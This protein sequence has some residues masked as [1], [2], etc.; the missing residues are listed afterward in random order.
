M[1]LALVAQSPQ[2]QEL[3]ENLILGVCKRKPFEIWSP[4]SEDKNG[5]LDGDLTKPHREIATL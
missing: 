1:L 3:R 2:N 5:F 4:S